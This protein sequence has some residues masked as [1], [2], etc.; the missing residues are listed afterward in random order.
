VHGNV[1]VM[2]HDPRVVLPVAVG[3]DHMVEILPIC[4]P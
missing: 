3:C 2:V 1:S 4:R